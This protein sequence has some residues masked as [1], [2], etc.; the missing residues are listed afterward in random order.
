MSWVAVCK[1]FC[2]KSAR[3][4]L[5][6]GAAKEECQELWYLKT[7]LPLPTSS[8]KFNCL[9]KQNMSAKLIK[10]GYQLWKIWQYWKY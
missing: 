8:T 10:T 3:L 1:Q 7:T 2:Y 5:T 4:L 9:N 6:T